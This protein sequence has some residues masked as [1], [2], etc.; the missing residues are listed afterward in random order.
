MPS[1]RFER[2]HRRGAWTPLVLEPLESRDLPSR[3]GVS[4]AIHT[5]RFPS[6]PLDDHSV[7]VAPA[8]KPAPAVQ[9]TTTTVGPLTV[10]LKLVPVGHQVCIAVKVSVGGS[11]YLPYLLDSGSVGMFVANGPN[12]PDEYKRTSTRFAQHYTS[13]IHY[14]G[15]AIETIRRLLVLWRGRTNCRHQSGQRAH[16]FGSRIAR[17][18]RRRDSKA[19]QYVSSSGT[20]TYRPG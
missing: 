1:N 7:A 2:R 16:H 6:R 14:D 19:S 5:S 20:A 3:F 10:P 15:S 11:P 12:G 8:V 17:H 9:A 18:R 4:S 13:G